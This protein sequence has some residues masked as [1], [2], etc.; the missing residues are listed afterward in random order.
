MSKI[1]KL[2]DILGALLH[3]HEADG[4]IPTN[5]RFL[6]YELVQRGQLSKEKTGVRRPDQDLHDALT[7]IREGGRIPWD[8]IVDETRSVDDFTGCNNIREGVLSTLPY[9]ELDPWCGEAPIILTESRSLAGVLRPIARKYRV[10]ITSTN[11]QVGGFLRTEIVPRLWK[12]A[13]VL[14]LGDYDLCGGQI[15]AN[16]RG[17]LEQ[18][19]GDLKWER[20]AL[21]EEQVK[22]YSLP[23]IMKSDKRYDPPRLHKAVETEAISQR[24]L[25]DLLTQR[26]EELLPEPLSRVLEREKRQREQILAKLKLR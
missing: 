14:Y 23:I 2:R 22:E 26:L 25:V 18:E 6:F 11:G 8:W 21:T 15:E 3:E 1:G 5:A 4:T 10:R 19:V 7:D 9:I 16:T 20:V 12:G 17:V 24:I 13:R